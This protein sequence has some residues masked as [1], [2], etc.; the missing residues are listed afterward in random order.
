M[1]NKQTAI[2]YEEAINE[3]L[4]NDFFEK[5]DRQIGF[6][7]GRLYSYLANQEKSI[8]KTSSLLTK[9]PLYTRRL[10]KQQILKVISKCDDVVR[11]LISKNKSEKSTGR[12]LRQKLHDLLKEDQWE[13]SFEELSLAFMMGFSFFVKSESETEENEREKEE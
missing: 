12:G 7:V 1:S 2:D 11:R 13:S 6:L 5:I 3:Y 4:K 8:L 9:L 10:N